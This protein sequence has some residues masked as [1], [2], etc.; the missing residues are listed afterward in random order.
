M[1]SF[2]S[3]SIPNADSHAYNVSYFKC[4]YMT[5]DCATAASQNL[6]S[7][8]QQKWHIMI[9]SQDCSMMN[10]ESNQLCNVFAI[11]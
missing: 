4:C 6:V 11:L 5:A 2:V 10:S 8:G 1:E 7:I 9:F 3:L